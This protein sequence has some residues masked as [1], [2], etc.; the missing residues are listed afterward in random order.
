MFDFQNVGEDANTA[1]HVATIT[2]FGQGV[3]SHCVQIDRSDIKDESNKLILDL[4]L[5][6]LTS[7]GRRSSTAISIGKS[8]PS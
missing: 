5:L 2:V 6:K 7:I 1:I 8:L 4:S 3:L